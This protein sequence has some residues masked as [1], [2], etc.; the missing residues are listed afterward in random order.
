MLNYRC[1]RFFELLLTRMHTLLIQS[2]SAHGISLVNFERC[3]RARVPNDL[4]LTIMIFNIASIFHY[5]V[6]ITEQLLTLCSLHCLDF[7]RAPSRNRQPTHNELAS[8]SCNDLICMCREIDD[9]VC[10][11]PFSANVQRIQGNVC[12][13]EKNGYGNREISPNSRAKTM[14]SVAIKLV[15][16]RAQHTG[17]CNVIWKWTKITYHGMVSYAWKT[18]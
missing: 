1:A 15:G 8:N 3:V 7:K 9:L 12:G 4:L 14:P 18:T 5:A 11:A 6:C 17:T 10:G 16:L 13:R 2:H